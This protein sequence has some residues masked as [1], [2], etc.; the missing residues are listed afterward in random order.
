MKKQEFLNNIKNQ[1]VGMHYDEMSKLLEFFE[2]GIEDRMEDGMSEEDAVA[3]LGDL[4]EIKRDFYAQEKLLEDL[5]EIDN[6]EVEDEK[7]EEHKS[8]EPETIFCSFENT[9]QNIYVKDKNNAVKVLASPD[10]QIYLEY[11]NTEFHSYE[12]NADHEIRVEC[13]STYSNEEGVLNKMFRLFQ[14]GLSLEKRKDLILRVPANYAGNLI[15]V[16]TNASIKV[17]HVIAQNI[18]IKSSNAKI[19]VANVV[20]NGNLVADTANGHIKAK[21]VTVSNRIEFISSNALHEI[22]DTK[23]ESIVSTTSNGII[24]ASRIHASQKIEF[25]TSNGAITVDEIAC[26]E[27][28]RVRTSNGNIKGSILGREEEYSI[29]LTTSN[30]K[31][32]LKNTTRETGK[33]LEATTSNG[34]ISLEFKN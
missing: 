29:L 27:D 28:I 8:T 33:N 22:F 30:G 6:Q 23:G 13:K 9:N 18:R 2:Q 3:S 15:L 4:D 19:E 20:V 34:N 24:M 16:S 25:T 5:D 1:F 17:D 31:K 14:K 12:L 10:D 7:E 11:T 32:S 21:D 26:D